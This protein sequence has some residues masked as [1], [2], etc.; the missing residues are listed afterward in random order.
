[1]QSL[2][3]VALY[4]DIRSD[5]EHGIAQ[6]VIRFAKQNGGWRLFGHGWTLDRVADIQRWQGMGIIAIVITAQE[7]RLLA[8]TRLSVVDVAGAV[9]HPALRQVTN[10]D[11]AT[12]RH[13]GEHLL[14]NGF[15]HFAYCGVAKTHWS[16]ERK[17]GFLSALGE[18][19]GRVESF[20]RIL[21][22]WEKPGVARELCRFLEK[23]PHP[24]GIMAANDTAGVKVTRACQMVGL[25][26]PQQAA[27]VGV[28]NEDILCEL[29]DPGLSSI[30]CD[31]NRIGFEAARRLDML[32]RQQPDGEVPLRIPPRPL[33]VRASS[34][35]I[36]CGDELVCRAVRF[37]R[38]NAG[39]PINVSDVVAHVAKC[40]RSVEA[41]FRRH[42]G[43]TVRDEIE[44]ARMERARRLLL[45]TTLPASKIAF[46]CGYASAQRFHAAFYAVHKQTPQ[47][48]RMP[49]RQDAASS[50]LPTPC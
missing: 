9:G 31:C 30:P 24:L 49:P 44:S 17:R 6:G 15:R 29:S 39:R 27:V 5:Y 46:A 7:A 35:T 42:R 11:T 4:M 19:A 36:A 43:R 40:R 21:P 18:A 1:M 25:E 38:E 26:L 16:E 22:W 20:E 8:Q 13:A 45:D 37:V 50:D 12:G 41:R 10:D 33:V 23:L 32:M 3:R 28:D 47:T 14:L 34:D 48:F 2:F